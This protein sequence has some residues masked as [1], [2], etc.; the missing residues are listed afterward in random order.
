MTPSASSS[1]SVVID[2]FSSVGM[3]RSHS[4]DKGDPTRKTP[5]QGTIGMRSSGQWKVQ[6]NGRFN[7]LFDELDEVEDARKRPDDAQAKR[8]QQ[9]CDSHGD[10]LLVDDDVLRRPQHYSLKMHKG[11][12]A[13]GKGKPI[14]LHT[15]K[16]AARQFVD[17]KSHGKLDNRRSTYGGHNPGR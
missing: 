15:M 10:V 8:V 6:L 7:G 9:E 14:H 12:Y 5:G 11:G 16:K 3:P 2:L 1:L 4:A 13:P 17:H